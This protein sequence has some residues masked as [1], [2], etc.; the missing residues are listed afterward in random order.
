MQAVQAAL[1]IYGAY[2]GGK[3]LIEGFKEGDIG[4]AI[5][6]G[7]SVF[8]S[9]AGGAS[10]LNKVGEHALGTAGGMAQ[11]TTEIMGLTDAI[12]PATQIATG[13]SEAAAQGA[14]SALGELSTAAAPVNP[15]EVTKLATSGSIDALPATTQG[16]KPSSLLGSA[17]AEP[18]T[19]ADTAVG[20]LQT[21][22][23]QP[24]FF[25]DMQFGDALG[26]PEQAGLYQPLQTVKQPGILNMVNEGVADFSADFDSII[27]WIEENETSATMLGQMI[28]GYSNQKFAEDYLDR[29]EKWARETRELRGGT[30][31]M[32]LRT[33]RSRTA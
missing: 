8:A 1:V 28:A 25:K 27:K 3:M 23:Q 26:L 15:T 14:Q 13:G 4:Q 22:A 30:P 19:I 31:T 2:T 29:Q 6:G 12:Q 24:G 7:L 17:G 32:P 10:M 16:I 18:L 11:S 20:G 21:G 33:P 5:L 9:V